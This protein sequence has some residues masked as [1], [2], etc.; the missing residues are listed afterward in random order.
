MN[1]RFEVMFRPFEHGRRP[2]MKMEAPGRNINNAAMYVK[3]LKP[4]AQIIA[5][6]PKYGGE[7]MSGRLL[8]CPF[9]GG[10]ARTEN[11]DRT[12]YDPKTFGV[13]DVE[14]G[15]PPCFWAEC[16]DCEAFVGGFDTEAEAITAW[17]RRPDRWIP[18]NERMPE[19]GNTVLMWHKDGFVML[20]VNM[21][22]AVDDVTHW[23]P[24][25]KG[26]KGGEN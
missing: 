8:P 22:D 9:C 6:W 16:G 21:F 11:N 13:V 17:N 3:H 10:E 18:V 1:K 12:I 25:P 20:A 19:E 26:P 4:T 14:Y 15:E 2:V 23:M 7:N 5:V 24:L